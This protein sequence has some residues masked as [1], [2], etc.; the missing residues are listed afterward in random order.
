MLFMLQCAGPRIVLMP[1]HR[2]KQEQHTLMKILL[3]A[4]AARVTLFGTS[5]TTE[6]VRSCR[7]SIPTF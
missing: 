7:K 5:A 1:T 4:G 2:L 6:K 3:V